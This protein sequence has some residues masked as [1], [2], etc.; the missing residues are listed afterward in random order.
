MCIYMY[1]YTYIHNGMKRY[2]DAHQMIFGNKL[3]II[4]CLGRA[5]SMIERYFFKSNYSCQNKWMH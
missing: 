1:I 3:L 2:N 4:A 5:N